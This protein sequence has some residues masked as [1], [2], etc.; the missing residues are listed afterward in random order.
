MRSTAP[1]RRPRPRAVLRG[2]WTLP[3]LQEHLQ[4]ALDIELWTI[5]YYLTALY[6]VK[7]PASEAAQL[8]RT[9]ANQEMLHMQL[10][11]NVANAY[12]GEV[13][14]SPPVYGEGI[15]HL[16]FDLDEPNP[17]KIFDPWSSELGP[18]DVTRLNTMCLIEYPDWQGKTNLDPDATEYG[19]IGDFY[20][21]VAIGA[22]EL[23]HRIVGGRNQLNVFGKF[24]PGFS[25]PTVTRDGE[26][27][28]PQVQQIL[29]AIVTQGEGRLS[30]EMEPHKIAK[31]PPWLRILSGFIPPSFQNQA[32]DLR[33]QAPHFD[34]FVYLKG[35]E[36]PATWTAGEPT[37]EGEA[38]QE[39][40]RRHF[41]E[42]CAILQAEMRGQAGEFSPVMF[43]IGGDIVSCWKHGAVPSFS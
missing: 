23:R 28:W 2:Q 8:I 20:H 21:S 40:L 37:R 1:L 11:A 4:Y 15:P 6:S 43:Q 10:A 22:E 5:P 25:T 33:Q 27:G 31:L 19:S 41:A 9:I 42:L 13:S 32:D 16:D 17:T 29:N 30:R 3:A 14:V 34:K 38:A 35:T 36:L 7:D 12:G 39:R 24:Y 18:L 26:Y